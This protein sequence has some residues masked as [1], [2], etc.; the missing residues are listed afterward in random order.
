MRCLCERFLLCD[1][2]SGKDYSQTKTTYHH[3]KRIVILKN[4]KAC[5]DDERCGN[6][7]KHGDTQPG[8]LNLVSITGGRLCEQRKTVRDQSE[9]KLAIEFR[10][11]TS[12]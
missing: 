11:Q 6:V 8:L 10:A 4:Y 12:T 1:V 7:E 2:A 9:A 5:C 3:N